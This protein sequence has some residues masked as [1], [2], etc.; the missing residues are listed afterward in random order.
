M[1]YYTTNELFP[2][3]VS[4]AIDGSLN[5]NGSGIG[6]S[7]SGL[8]LAGE[9]FGGFDKGTRFFFEDCWQRCEIWTRSG[10][11]GW[12][13]ITKSASGPAWTGRWNRQ[14]GGTRRCKKPACRMR[15]MVVL[16]ASNSIRLYPTK[17]RSL[18]K[19]NPRGRPL[20]FDF[21]SLFFSCLFAQYVSLRIF[22]YLKIISVSKKCL[23]SKSIFVSESIFCIFRLVFRNSPPPTQVVL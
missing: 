2:H 13:S 9:G 14:G 10:Q 12:N 23:I 4:H 11:S 5:L 1:S 8:S 16:V 7:G 20:G 22:T 21:P 17:S 18:S 3:R 19:Y 6:L 15:K